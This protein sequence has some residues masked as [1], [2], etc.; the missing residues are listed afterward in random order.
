M[1]FARKN[2][3][4]FLGIPPKSCPDP[5]V[6]I[7][8]VVRLECWSVRSVT[9]ATTRLVITQTEDAP[10]VSGGKRGT[11]NQTLNTD[12][13]LQCDVIGIVIYRCDITSD[14]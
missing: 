1:G 10:G 4:S 7:I 5:L 6:L 2:N 8:F 11:T 12:I 3:Y 9:P 14:M 13:Y